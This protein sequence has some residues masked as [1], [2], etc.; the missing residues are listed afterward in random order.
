MAEA[1]A[2]KVGDPA[3]GLELPDT[4]GR[5]HTLPMPGE[6]SAARAEEPRAG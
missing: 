4:E 1:T 3:P 2:M 5:V 6:A